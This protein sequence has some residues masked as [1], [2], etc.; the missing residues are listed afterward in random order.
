MCEKNKRNDGEKGENNEAKKCKK[1][2]EDEKM[3]R[4]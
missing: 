1:K 2:G 3:M 4:R